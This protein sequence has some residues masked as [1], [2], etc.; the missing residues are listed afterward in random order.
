M[1]QKISVQRLP[2]KLAAFLKLCGA[3]LTGGEASLVISDGAVSVNGQIETRRGRQLQLGDLVTL[4]GAGT[5]QVTAQ[6]GPNGG[7][8][9]R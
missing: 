5:W 8:H 7:S 1:V 9:V 3:V 6:P 2:I 4:D